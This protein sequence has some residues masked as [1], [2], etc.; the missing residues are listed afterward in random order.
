[1]RTLDNTDFPDDMSPIDRQ[2]I[3]TLMNAD[4]ARLAMWYN[5][6]PVSDITYAEMLMQRMHNYEKSKEKALISA[7]DMPV[8]DCNEAVSYLSKFRLQ[9]S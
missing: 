2:N 7:W 6:A 8:K 1:M 9:K 4:P 3:V 5:T